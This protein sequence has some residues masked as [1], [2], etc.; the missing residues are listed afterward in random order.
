MKLRPVTDETPIAY[1]KDG[2]EIPA[3]RLQRW[4]YDQLTAAPKLAE[5]LQKIERRLTL[6][7]RAFYVDGTPS[8]LREALKG[9]KDDIEPARAALKDAGI[10]VPA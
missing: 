3:D 7:A 2:T 6:A 10:E 8:K 9:W 4:A 5:A 1:D